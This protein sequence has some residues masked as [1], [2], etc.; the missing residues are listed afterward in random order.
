MRTSI[1]QR[2]SDQVAKLATITIETGTPPVDL[3]NYGPQVLVDDNP[4]RVAKIDSTTGAWLFT[5]LAAQRV[6]L[7]GL[8]HHDFDAGGNVRIQGNAINTWGAPSLNALITIPPWLGVGSRWPLNPW[9]DLTGVA[10]YTTTGY[11]F[12]RLII[13]SNSQNLQ[14]GQVWL[15]PTIRLLDDDLQWEYVQTPSKRVIE[16]RTAFG[17][18]TIYS[19]GTTEWKLQGGHLMSDA[20]Q[21]LLEEQWYDVDGRSNP[22]L[23]VPNGDVNRCYFVRYADTMRGVTHI[24]DD[25]H[26]HQFNVEEVSRGLRPGE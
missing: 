23:L 13:T 22:W 15:S 4:A 1:Y 17:V 9:L 3:T 19:R 2:Y 8:I 7:I 14:L 21:A 18:S 24:V 10:G 25:V 6:D 20:L 26:S 12:W 5:F 16:N 11:Q